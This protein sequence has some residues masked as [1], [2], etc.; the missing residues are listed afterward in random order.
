MSHPLGAG[1]SL[2]VGVIASALAILAF[3]AYRRSHDRRLLFV[4]GA[5]TAFAIKGI[6]TFIDWNASIMSHSTL[7]IVSSGLDLVV[8]LF[9]VAP[10]LTR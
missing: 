6:L 2:T 1:F 7:S 5:F 8:V 9:L 10:F 4:L 3:A